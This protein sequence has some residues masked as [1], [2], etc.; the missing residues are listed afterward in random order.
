[1]D[2]VLLNSYLASTTKTQQNKEEKV[3]LNKLKELFFMNK[4]CVSQCIFGVN[5][6]LST[7]LFLFV[8]QQ[9]VFNFSPLQLNNLSLDIITYLSP[10]ILG[11]NIFLLLPE[12]V[13]KNR[14]LRVKVETST[15][16]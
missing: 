13:C 12:S 2:K 6:Q 9:N 14:K 11:T 3:Y 4:L 10:N 7:R 8:V 16:V 5:V 15:W 1:M